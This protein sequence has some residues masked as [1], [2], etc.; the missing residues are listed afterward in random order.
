[1]ICGIRAEGE[2]LTSIDELFRGASTD[3]TLDC[4]RS[5]FKKR[6]TS[7]LNL[8]RVE[9]YTLLQQGSRHQYLLYLAT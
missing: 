3:Y 5:D 1:M 9:T 8:T 4:A 6:H 7:S 2:K